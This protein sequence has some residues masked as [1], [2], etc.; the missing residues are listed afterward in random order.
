M[1]SH[2]QRFD[3]RLHF[4]LR[5]ELAA[6]RVLEARGDF[7]RLAKLQLP[8]HFEIDRYRKP[9]VDGMH[10]DV[11]HRQAWLRAITITRSMTVSLVERARIG[12]QHHLGGR[13]RLLHRLDD[14][15][16]SAA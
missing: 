11:M 16:P 2:L 5:A 8:F 10:G 7:V 12:C 9:A 15:D 3:M 13:K 14:V 6:D 1:P 4:H